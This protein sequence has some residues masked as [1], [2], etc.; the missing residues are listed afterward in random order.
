MK[1]VSKDKGK[2]E[3]VFDVDVE[4]DEYVEDKIM[5]KNNI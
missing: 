1:K 3:N 2:E 5:K 4:E